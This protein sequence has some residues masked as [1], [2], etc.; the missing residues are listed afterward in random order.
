MSDYDDGVT[1]DD[2]Y[3]G[4]YTPV[5]GW[6]ASENTIS[7]YFL[8][9]LSLLAL[10]LILSSKLHHSHWLA[11]IL[12]EAGLIIIVGIAAGAF[13]SIF[14]DT[15]NGSNGDDVND[16]G[17]HNGDVVVDGLLSF[18]PKVF[19]VALLPPIIFNSGYHIKRE[20]FFRHIVAIFLYACIGT[21]ISTAVVAMFM[22]M[23]VRSDLTGGFAPSLAENLTF[24]ALISATDPVSTLAVFQMK[25]VDPQ[26]FYLVFGESVM[27][28]AVGLVLFDALSK[29][30]GHEQSIGKDTIAAVGFFIDFGYIFVGSLVLGVVSGAMVAYILKVVDMR[31]TRLLELSLYVLIIYLPFFAAETLR[32]SG[33]VTILFTGISAK[34]YAE[35][36]LSD[37][38]TDDADSLFRVLAHLAESAIFLELGLSLFGLPSGVAHVKFIFWAFIACLLGRALNVYPISFFYNRYLGK[39]VATLSGP[40]DAPLVDDAMASRIRAEKEVDM[41]TSHMLWFSGLRGAVAYACA[42]T[43]PDALGNRSSFVSITMWIILLTVF[44]FGSTTDCALKSL[45]IETDIDEDKYLKERPI[46]DASFLGKIDR[47]MC[48]VTI[49]GF[50][51]LP[52]SPVQSIVE[53]NSVC[54]S[55][56]HQ[57]GGIEIS[58]SFH[59]DASNLEGYYTPDGYAIKEKGSLYDFGGSPGKARTASS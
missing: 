37:T 2:G 21:T 13:F 45:H 38:T 56:R 5:I 50:Q 23:V 40:N 36:N 49:R 35:P 58:E 31:E 27:N 51:S 34:R 11:S 8:L 3:N 39:K 17:V 59:L 33:I 41:K 43:F 14:E 10:V 20:L 24:G 26:L 4:S 1:D 44:V 54:E 7:V 9:F 42:K 6:T 57:D 28:D 12:P 18:S 22:E 25:R 30:V 46:A 16:D 15:G 52:R 19:F 55:D 48:P 32:L 29:F 53:M 47:L